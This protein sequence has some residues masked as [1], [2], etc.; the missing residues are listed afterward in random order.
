[1]NS[2]GCRARGVP[3]Y[4]GLGPTE[5]HLARFPSTRIPNEAQV[6]TPPVQGNPQPGIQP[7]GIFSLEAEMSV[8]LTSCDLSQALFLLKRT[9]PGSG[10]T[11]A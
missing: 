3:N 11:E 7:R 10:E 2:A 9:N 8:L 1:M 5:Q 4:M 6:S